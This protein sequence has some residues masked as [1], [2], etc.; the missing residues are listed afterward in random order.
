MK[1]LAKG[2][3]EGLKSVDMGLCERCVM[4]KQKL[5]SFTNTSKESKEVRLELVH[6]DVW[7]PS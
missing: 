3:L 6:I 7:K 1:M 4:G 2:V 5:V